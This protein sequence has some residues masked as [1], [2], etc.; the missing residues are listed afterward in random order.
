MTP[1]ATKKARYPAQ[2]GLQ[3]PHDRL[4][5]RSSASERR[6]QGGAEGERDAPA[7]VE[8][9][10]SSRLGAGKREGVSGA[11]RRRG[12]PPAHH[13]V[14]SNAEKVSPCR[15]RLFATSSSSSSSSSLS[16]SLSLSSSSTLL[17][18]TSKLRR[19]KTDGR[20]SPFGP[21]SRETLFFSC[22]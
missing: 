5:R 14:E 20:A 13:Q 7:E 22:A 8:G 18:S 2:T 16:S 17:L 9:A 4:P 3:R 12:G 6:A 1:T 19:G 10:D 15:S 11:R 21:R